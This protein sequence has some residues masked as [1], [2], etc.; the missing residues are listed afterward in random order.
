MV[1]R[2][3]GTLNGKRQKI[4]LRRRRGPPATPKGF[5]GGPGRPVFVIKKRAKKR[6]R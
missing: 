2:N 4:P 3:I 5:K 1:G 6:K